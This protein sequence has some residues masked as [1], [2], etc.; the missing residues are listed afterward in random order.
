M[1]ASF[2]PLKAKEVLLNLN[3][4]LG[5]TNIKKEQ[6]RLR[7][8]KVWYEMWFANPQNDELYQTWSS[9]W[10]SLLTSGPYSFPVPE[11]ITKIAK[12]PLTSKP[13]LL[14]DGEAHKLL[15]VVI[16][17]IQKK[18]SHNGTVVQKGQIYTSF[19]KTL[20]NE[21]ILLVVTVKD[22]A[23]ILITSSKVKVKR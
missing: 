21:E 14:I 11:T 6:L 17:P 20:N 7:L 5:K 4:L 18:F 19:P 1:T 23:D 2:S 13:M 16:T 12:K 9:E 15:D 3:L 8:I 10:S 22:R